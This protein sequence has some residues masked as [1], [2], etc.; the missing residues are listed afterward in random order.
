MATFRT[1]AIALLG[2]AALALSG[3]SGGTT[4]AD[5]GPTDTAPAEAP[6]DTGPVGTGPSDIGAPDAS[7]PGDTSG[8][9]SSNGDTD[10]QPPASNGELPA[11]YEDA[12][13]LAVNDLTIT[14]EDWCVSPEQDQFAKADWSAVSEGESVYRFTVLEGETLDLTVI[15]ED[16][17]QW[18]A[19]SDVVSQNPAGQYVEVMPLNMDA[20]HATCSG[21]TCEPAG[22]R[23]TAEGVRLL[24]EVSSGEAVYAGI[25]GTA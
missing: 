3:C 1:L 11:G 9:S 7:T 2:A 10:G 23:Y 17:E 6:P 14:C 4:P 8:D 19:W 18:P 22:E 5:T 13:I 15:T 21:G 20:D 25:T 24:Y 16:S 12:V